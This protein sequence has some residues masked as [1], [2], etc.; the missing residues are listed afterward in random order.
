MTPSCSHLCA[1][2]PAGNGDESCWL[3]HAN[4]SAVATPPLLCLIFRLCFVF[5]QYLY[6]LSVTDKEKADKLTQS[7]PPGLHKKHI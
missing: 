4:V 5:I 3:H 2:V 1:A 7:L 6:T